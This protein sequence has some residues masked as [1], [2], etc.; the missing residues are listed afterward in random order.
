M[1][2]EFKKT[3]QVVLINENG[4]VL[5]VSRK[6][7]HSDFGLPGGKMEPEDKDEE[8]TAIRETKEETGLDIYDLQLIFATHKYGF[9]SYTYIAKYSGEINHNEPHLVQWVP[10]QVIIDG[11]FGEFNQ[12]VANSLESMGMSF[13][14][15]T[16]TKADELNEFYLEFYNEIVKSQEDGTLTAKCIDF[17][18]KIT[19]KSLEKVL[20]KLSSETKEE[21][22][23]Y[24]FDACYKRFQNFKDSNDPKKC[25]QYFRTVIEHALFTTLSKK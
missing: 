2:I 12:L 23:S 13:Q 9:M 25:H 18:K 5:G 11:S 8:A 14:K 19:N 7:N 4:L 22:L 24:A 16:K 6:D 3:S 20:V 21:L 1:E 17:I 10:F 15:E